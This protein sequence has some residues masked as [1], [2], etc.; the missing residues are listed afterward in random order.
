MSRGIFDSFGSG[1]YDG[2]DPVL[3]IHHQRFW[4]R[5]ASTGRT[6]GEGKHS[7]RYRSG[8]Q[9]SLKQHPPSVRPHMGYVPRIGYQ[10]S[11]PAV[12]RYLEIPAN[13]LQSGGAD[14]FSKLR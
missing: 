9:D 12:S 14:A 2:D 5:F 13:P 3:R 8:Q 10:P 4:F 7:S 1:L 6:S 11:M